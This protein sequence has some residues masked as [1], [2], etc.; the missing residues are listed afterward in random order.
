GV[1]TGLNAAF[2]IDEATRNELIAA[3]PR[4]ADVIK[5]WLRGRDVKRWAVEWD[6]L[7]VI[8]TRRGIDIDQ[9]PAI[10]AYLAQYRERLEPGKKGGRKPGSYK[11]Y[12]IQ[13][14]VAYYEK[15]DK[16]KIIWPDIAKAPTFAYDSGGFF[17][18]TTT[19]M[20]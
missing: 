15:F 20:F 13:D 5:P 16:P 18:D 10:K 17:T 4:S 1:L 12:E 2:V 8:F 7:Y 19:Y 9:Y 11:W 14:S 3:D 6:G